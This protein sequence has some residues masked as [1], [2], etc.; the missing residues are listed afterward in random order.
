MVQD[1]RYLNKWKIK[2][3]YSLLFI[4]DIIK[5]IGTKEVF[6]KLDLW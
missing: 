6:I 4:L 2:N 5:N 3:K 1:Y